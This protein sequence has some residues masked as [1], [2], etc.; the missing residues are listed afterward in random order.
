[1]THA[2]SVMSGTRMAVLDQK[3]KPPASASKIKASVK[4]NVRT[5]PPPSLTA[6]LPLSLTRE[7]VE[8]RLEMR[9][10]N[11]PQFMNIGVTPNSLPDEIFSHDNSNPLPNSSADGVDPMNVVKIKVEDDDDAN[12]IIDMAN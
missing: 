11:Q 8:R 4:Q 1:M 3:K 9:R 5:I 12:L 7:E 2:V 6:M 10:I